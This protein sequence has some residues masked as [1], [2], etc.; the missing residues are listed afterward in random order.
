MKPDLSS[1]YSLR[2]FRR[3]LA[4][5]EALPQ[6]AFLGVISGIVTGLIILAFRS[7]IEVPLE[8]LLP[9]SGFEGFENL[10]ATGRFLLPACGGL[11][12]AAILIFIPA[13]FCRVGVTHVLERLSL[14]QGHLPLGNALVQFFAGSLALMTGQSVGREGPAIHLGAAGSSLIGHY[15]KLPHNSTRVLVG[16]GVAGAISASFNTPLAGVI[17]S[18]EVI[19]MEYTMAGFI[20]VILSAVTAN[21]IGRLVYGDQVA[22]NIPQITMNSLYDI[23]YILLAGLVLGMI[24]A[25]FIKLVHLVSQFAPGKL[26]HRMI[27]GGTLTGSLALWVPEIMGVGYDTVN[28]ALTGQLGLGLLATIC[29]AKLVAS[30]ASVGLGM[31]AGLI[32]PTMFIGAAAGGLFGVIG[33]VLLPE[34]VSSPGFYVLMGMGA[35]MG[36]VLQAPLSALLAVMELSQN[37]GIILPAMLVIVVSNLTTRQI[38]GQQSIY[39][40]MLDIQGLQLRYNP[41]SIAL[42]R[43]SVAS[44][45]ERRYIRLP[46]LIARDQLL[47]TLSEDPEWLLV[48]ASD[49][50]SF[51]ML[52]DDLTDF[53]EAQAVTLEEIDL[54]LIPVVRR[55][56]A[57]ISLQATLSEALV[58][59]NQDRADALYVHR[60]GLDVDSIEGVLTRQDIESEYQL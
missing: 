40:S 14:H 33:T 6:F 11:A 50:P 21:L 1:D 9:G 51:V 59:L 39:L 53:L 45:M 47:A 34:Y 29:L 31:P 4:N 16:C 49:R 57:P 26:W 54:S 17:F 41:L 22:F 23:P 37:P 48:Q 25:L 28:S 58:K 2:G 52:K 20:P 56:V 35:M 8:W 42:N 60:G 46:N 38:F 5:I 27:L 13:R 44:I 3:R 32:G 24:A 10:S 19:L 15:L 30:A 43:A 18:M 12:L 36:A 7:L 55:K